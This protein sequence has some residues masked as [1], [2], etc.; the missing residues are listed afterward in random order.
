MK[1]RFKINRKLKGKRFWNA[2][3]MGL[4]IFSGSAF[5]LPSISAQSFSNQA[6]ANLKTMQNNPTG[7]I[8]A[9]NLI[10]PN[11]FDYIDELN[12][13]FVK[14]SDVDIY[15][16]NL[17]ENPIS[18]TEVDNYGLINSYVEETLKNIPDDKF[19]VIVKLDKYKE[20]K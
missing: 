12:R 15:P 19:A 4:L 6:D 20:E 5:A 18:K 13:E 14:S 11:D 10:L 2:F 16:K 1:K 8:N 7:I 17:T 9:D 3:A